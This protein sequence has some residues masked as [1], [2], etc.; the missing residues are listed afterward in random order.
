[1]AANLSLERSLQKLQGYG[2]EI[3]P[4]TDLFLRARESGEITFF[5]RPPGRLPPF[6]EAFDVEVAG[7]SIP[8][9]VVSGACLGTEIRLASTTLPF[10]AVTI[11]SRACKRL[12]L[13]N[14]GDV[15]ARF[16]WDTFALGQNFSIFPCDGFL[17]PGRD[18]KLEVTFHP[19]VVSQDIRV[20][21]VRCQVD[22]GFLAFDQPR[23]RIF[24]VLFD[25]LN[26]AVV[27]AFLLN[28]INL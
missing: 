12:Q 20:E 13:E 5:F 22:G 15:G 10:N 7:V 11:G 26:T 28:N 9:L 19:T 14:T 16:V 27:N 24:A 17:P 6:S 23:I 1:M 3:L 2:I 18:V 25:S 8:L 21:R 4:R